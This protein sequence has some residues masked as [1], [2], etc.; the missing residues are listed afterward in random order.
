M[1]LHTNVSLIN[2][3]GEMEEVK[4]EVTYTYTPASRGYRN[5]LGVPEEPDEDEDLDI[6]TVIDENGND[7]LS[8]LTDSQ[9]KELIDECMS[10]MGDY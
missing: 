1:L 2:A 7:R 4:V 6:E 8:E 9:V 10:D 3:D 5:S